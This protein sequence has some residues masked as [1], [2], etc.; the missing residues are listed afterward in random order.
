MCPVCAGG[1]GLA[2]F[3]AALAAGFPAAFATDFAGGFVSLTVTLAGFVVGGHGRSFRL[4]LDVGLCCRFWREWGRGLRHGAVRRSRDRRC[5]TNGWSERRH[6]CGDRRG[7]RRRFGLGD[8]RFFGG[9]L[10][11]GGLCLFRGGPLVVR[12]LSFADELVGF[13]RSHLAALHH[14]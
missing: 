3:T 6:R 4:G 7:T 10:G 2:D 12:H 14:V 9:N 5:G 11:G 8:G 13:F 1:A